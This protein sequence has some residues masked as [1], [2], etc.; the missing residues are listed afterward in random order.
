MGHRMFSMLSSGMDRVMS[1]FTLWENWRFVLPQSQFHFIVVW[2]LSTF[3]KYQKYM[4][5]PITE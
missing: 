2:L 4:E 5:S 3:T 1:L